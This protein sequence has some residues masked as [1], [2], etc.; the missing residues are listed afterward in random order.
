[1]IHSY[2][3]L[4]ASIAFLVGLVSSDLSAQNSDHLSLNLIFK[5]SIVDVNATYQAI[6]NE[7]VD[8]VFFL[9]NPA[10]ELDTIKSKGLKSYKVT[11][12]EGMPLNFSFWSL[13]RTGMKRK[14][15][16]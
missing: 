14:N 4:I 9:L 5:D 2:V 12:K 6:F 8:S 10:F 7:K 3:R 13:M 16:L 15:Y 1:M 11:Q